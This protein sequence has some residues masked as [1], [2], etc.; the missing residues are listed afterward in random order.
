MLEGWSEECLSRSLVRKQ[1]MCTSREAD[2]EN[3][4]DMQKVLS[5]SQTKSDK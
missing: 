2:D 3:T 4:R 1:T 5:A